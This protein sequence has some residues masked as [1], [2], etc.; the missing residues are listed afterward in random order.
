MTPE[1]PDIRPSDLE[2]YT[3]VAHILSNRPLYHFSF[4][5]SFF[6]AEREDLLGDTWRDIELVLA[7]LELPRQRIG[8]RFHRVADVTYSGYGQIMGLYV[9]GIEERGWAKLRYEVGDYEDG[10]IRLFCHSVSL[11]DPTKV[12]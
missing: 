11:Y 4:V 3:E 1:A 9:Q 8:F 2:G 5:H 10:R 12:A 7:E 6:F